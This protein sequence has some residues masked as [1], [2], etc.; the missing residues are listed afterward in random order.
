MLAAHTAGIEADRA[1]CAEK[2]GKSVTLITAFLPRIG[3][4][5]AQALVREFI[6]NKE[7]VFRLF[8]ENKLGKTAVDEV[9]S[10]QNILSLGHK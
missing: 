9:L 3:Y 8:L 6:D 4:D 1:V 10:P 7:S 5:K 2:S